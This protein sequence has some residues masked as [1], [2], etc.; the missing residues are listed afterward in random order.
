MEKGILSEIYHFSI[1]MFVSGAS[2][3]EEARI[4]NTLMRLIFAISHLVSG[5]E[6]VQ[7]SSSWYAMLI[8]TLPFIGDISRIAMHPNGSSS[9][10]S[11]GSDGRSIEYTHQIDRG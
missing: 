7:I 3:V 1:K 11:E 6:Q 5:H 10:G 4:A 8:V 9:I 2:S